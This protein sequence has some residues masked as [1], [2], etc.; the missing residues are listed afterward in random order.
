MRRRYVL[1]CTSWD[2]RLLFFGLY[3]LC[4]FL[5]CFSP[6]YL[7]QYAFKYA[8]AKCSMGL[9][10]AIYRVEGGNK[11]IWFLLCNLFFSFCVF[12]VLSCQQPCWRKMSFNGAPFIDEVLEFNLSWTPCGCQV[13]T[14]CICKYPE[15]YLVSAYNYFCN[16]WDKCAVSSGH[17]PLNAVQLLW[18]NLIQDTLG[19]LALATEP[20]TDELMH[21]PPVGRREPLINNIMWRNLLIQSLYQVCV[22]LVLNYRGRSLLNLENDSSDYADKVKNTLIFNAYVLCQI[23]NEFNARRPDGLNIFKGITRNYLF[24]AIVGLTLVIQVILIE[25]LGTFTSSVKLNWKQWLISIII[26]FISW[27]L[28]TIGKLI[29]V[30]RTPLNDYLARIL[31]CWQGS[32]GP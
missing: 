31:C 8:D 3:I 17:V 18:I 22:L 4:F 21:R 13:G 10:I 23:F 30:P 29:P 25:F 7:W 9:H 27:P 14:T 28:A 15:I 12:W 19:A 2:V 20:P 32:W 16:H 26:A 24:L 5:F 1:I 11:I 6:F